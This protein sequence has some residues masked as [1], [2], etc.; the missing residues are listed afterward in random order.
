MLLKHRGQ[1]SVASVSE[2]KFARPALQGCLSSRCCDL[3]PGGG[4]ARKSCSLVQ[5]WEVCWGACPSVRL[6]PH[7]HTASGVPGQ[8]SG[9]L[10]ANPAL[11]FSSFNILAF[12]ISPPAFIIVHCSEK[13]ESRLDDLRLDF[14]LKNY[15]VLRV[16]IQLFSKGLFSK[17]KRK[18]NG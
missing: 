18:Q 12:H 16:S 10:L 7:T 2:G 9:T 6:L 15:V 3:H 4:E 1:N 11:P 5:A 8:C 14:D 13:N 17:E